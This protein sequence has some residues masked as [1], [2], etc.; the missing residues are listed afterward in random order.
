MDAVHADLTRTESCR[1]TRVGFETEGRADAQQPGTELAMTSFENVV[2]IGR[3]RDEV[4][5]FLADLEKVPR[6][7]PAIEGTMK[8]TYR[9]VRV[10]T[11]YR[12]VR[13]APK[14]SEESFEITRVRPPACDRGRHRALPGPDRLRAGN[15]PGGDA[16]DELGGAPPPIISR[17]MVPLA[18][19]Q[20]RAAVA[21]NLEPR[22]A[23]KAP[24]GHATPH[25]GPDGSCPVPAARM[26]RGLP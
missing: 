4:F 6:W 26:M 10:G 24:R 3:P 11:T 7:N 25:L 9:P 21:S 13:S 17:V 16:I 12:Q 19:S 8:A 23:E 15:R 14:R 22:T 1:R 2:M 18:A 5:A 20:I